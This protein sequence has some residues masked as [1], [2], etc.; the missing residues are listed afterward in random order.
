LEDTLLKDSIAASP[1]DSSVVKEKKHSPKLAGCLS[2]VVP[3]LGQAYNKKYWKIPIDYAGFAA[4]GYFVYYFHSQYVA[5]RNEYRNRLNGETELLNPKWKGLHIDN[6]NMS[7]QYHQQNMQISIIALAAWYLV[8][9][10]DA[11]VDAHLMSFD[12]SDN[13][14]LYLTP[15][16]NTN[17]TFVKQKLG[18]T[19][20]FNIK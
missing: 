13:L 7:R 16:F 11:V 4:T 2:A 15:D 20:T 5:Y 10:L 9:I 18:L 1:I 19:F 14:S 12:V 3:G 6:I 8:N 17:P